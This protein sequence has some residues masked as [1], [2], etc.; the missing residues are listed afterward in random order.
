M[1]LEVGNGVS[2]KE[3]DDEGDSLQD[4]WLNGLDW[5]DHKT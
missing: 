3:R 2:R 1:S 5:S 4:S